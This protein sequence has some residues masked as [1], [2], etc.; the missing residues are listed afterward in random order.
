MSELWE[1]KKIGD[2]NSSILTESGKY[3]TVSGDV[4]HLTANEIIEAYNT[5]VKHLKAQIA[6]RDILLLTVPDRS[7]GI[8]EFRNNIEK[9]YELNPT[10]CGGSFG[11]LLCYEI[12]SAGLTFVELAKKWSIGVTFLGELIADHCVKMEP[13]PSP[14]GQSS[15][16]K[17]THV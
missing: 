1:V 5:S 7:P 12:H 11:E 17:A 4:H 6:V 10:G 9:I 2:Y 15:P 16:L 8:F 3:I 14:P 13:L